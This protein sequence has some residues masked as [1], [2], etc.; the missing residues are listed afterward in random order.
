MIRP[1][2]RNLGL[3]FLLAGLGGQVHA[4]NF[5][6]HVILETNAP[7]IQLVESGDRVRAMS[8]ASRA[9]ARVSSNR[10]VPVK[11]VVECIAGPNERF[12]DPRIDAQFRS[13]PL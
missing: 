8:I 5:A 12:K 9:K 10:R 13:M 3:L 11:Q 4:E 6:C 1:F 7:Y 2:L